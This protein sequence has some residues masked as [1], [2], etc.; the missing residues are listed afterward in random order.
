MPPKKCSKSPKTEQKQPVWM[1]K[2]SE[3]RKLPK[4]ITKKPKTE[5]EALA[6]AND[7]IKRMRYLNAGAPYDWGTPT[8]SEVRAS[9][10]TR[11]RKQQEKKLKT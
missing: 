10:L 11:Y 7:E 2:K 8:A 6:I 5:A 9:T 1:M 3:R 4:T